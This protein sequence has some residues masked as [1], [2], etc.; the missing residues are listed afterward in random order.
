[1]RE[2]TKIQNSVMMYQ[3]GQ[4]NRPDERSVPA[5]ESNRSGKVCRMLYVL[6][7]GQFDEQLEGWFGRDDSGH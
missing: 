5:K 6:I 3:T 2:I 1:M 4:N 7:D